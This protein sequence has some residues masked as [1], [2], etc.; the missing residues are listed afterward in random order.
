MSEREHALS[1][2]RVASCPGD[3]WRAIPDGVG[4]TA[5]GLAHFSAHPASFAQSPC[6]CLS[7]W[8]NFGQQSDCATPNTP[9]GEGTCA[10]AIAMGG[11]ATERAT[12][13]MRMARIKRMIEEYPPL[14]PPVK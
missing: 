1:L 5:E 14:L 8:F 10:L 13:A 9:S 3:G 7:Q 6:I 4:L 2:T 11:M 12:T